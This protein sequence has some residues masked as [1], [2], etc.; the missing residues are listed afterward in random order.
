MLDGSVPQSYTNFCNLSIYLRD[1]KP[2]N[3]L[4]TESGVAKISDFGGKK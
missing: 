3:V 4:I 1:L 2:E